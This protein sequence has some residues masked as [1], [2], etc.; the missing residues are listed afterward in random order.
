MTIDASM[1]QQGSATQEIARNVEEAA[2]GTKQVTADISIVADGANQTRL[3]SGR[4][5]SAADTLMGQA[6]DL[7]LDVRKFLDAVQAV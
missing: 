5:V 3:V 2:S 4:V 1:G 6:N 7:R